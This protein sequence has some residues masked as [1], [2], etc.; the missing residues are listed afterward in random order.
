MQDIEE[1][2]LIYLLGRLIKL[3][4]IIWGGDLRPLINSSTVRIRYFIEY[5]IFLKPIFKQTEFTAFLSYL[6]GAPVSPNSNLFKYIWIIEKQSK[7]FNEA[8]YILRNEVLVDL[9]DLNSVR[10]FHHNIKD[11]KKI[12]TFIKSD[13]LDA[14]DYLSKYK[15]INN[16][17]CYQ[18][19]SNIISDVRN[20]PYELVKAKMD[21]IFWL[22]NASGR[23]P[24]Q[25]WLHKLTSIENKIE[26]ANLLSITNWILNN[27]QLERELSTGWKDD[28]F[29]RFQKSAKWYQY[30]KN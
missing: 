11:F 9:L 29:I 30:N 16:Q 15:V 18:A 20:T 25:A 23:S 14:I 10:G 27:T 21:I 24:K 8:D 28:V 6:K 3:Y 7:F 12:L 1:S 4:D 26:K 17:G 5:A 22:D 2:A 13:N 19:I